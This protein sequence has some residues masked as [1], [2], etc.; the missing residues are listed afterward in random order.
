M[1]R[2]KQLHC[3][4]TMKRRSAK[5]APGHFDH[6]GP[7]TMPTT[8]LLSRLA[9]SLGFILFSVVAQAQPL[10]MASIQAMPDGDA[11]LFEGGWSIVRPEGSASLLTCHLPT[12]LIPDGNAAL[13]YRDIA[14]REIRFSVTA[15]AENTLWTGEE[16]QTAVWTGT[17]SFL[18]YPHRPDGSINVDNATLFERCEVWPRQSYDGAV[19]G[20]L[21]PFVGDWRESLPADRGGAPLDRHTSCDDP[22]TYAIVGEST[23]EMTAEGDEPQTIPVEVRDGETIFPNEGYPAAVIWISPDRWHL[24]LPGMDRQPDWNLPIILERCPVTE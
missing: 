15:T 12:H 23:L 8:R 16:S 24:H 18:L 4:P 17:D 7:D 9:T 20:D 13:V 22:T 2:E 3:R 1:G 10:P 6:T 19:A 5:N 11:S 21:A 14:G